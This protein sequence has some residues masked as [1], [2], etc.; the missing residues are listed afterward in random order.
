MSTSKSFTDFIRDL[1]DNE[2]FEKIGPGIALVQPGNWQGIVKVGQHH[3][4]EFS[5]A[6]VYTVMKDKPD[7]FKA[8]PCD[9]SLAAWSLETLSAAL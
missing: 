6:E 3:G 2:Q 5:L 7:A 8:M 9:S 4:Y 1:K